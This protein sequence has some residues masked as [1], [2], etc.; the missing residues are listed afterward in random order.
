MI[1]GVTAD[2]G[3]IDFAVLVGSANEGM[4]VSG[5]SGCSADECY[6]EHVIPGIM[7][8]GGIADSTERRPH[9]ELIV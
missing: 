9:A 4:D 7:V 3:I 1:S 2:D 8:V 6:I 5:V